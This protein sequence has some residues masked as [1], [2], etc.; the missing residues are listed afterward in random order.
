[1]DQVAVSF[2]YYFSG[3]TFQDGDD[4]D[5]VYVRSTLEE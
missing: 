4:G 3:L 1:M 2:S 5:D